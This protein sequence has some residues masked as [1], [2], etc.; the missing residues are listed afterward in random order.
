M[1]PH[2]ICN[3]GHI[4]EQNMM[5]K[6]QSISGYDHLYEENELRKIFGWPSV[7]VDFL[8]VKGNN[9]IAIQTKYRKT[10]RREDHG[11]GKFVKSI[12]FVLQ[13]S[14]KNLIAGLW[15]SRIRPFDDNIEFLSKRKISCLNNFDNMDTLIEDTIKYIEHL[16]YGLNQIPNCL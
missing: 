4:F 7:G 6:L 15:V 5:L 13:M 14:N 10:R 3:K 16:L 9:V 1:N 8:L 12:D 11:I 2:D